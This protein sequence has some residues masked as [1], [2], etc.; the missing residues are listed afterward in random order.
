MTNFFLSRFNYA[1]KLVFAWCENLFNKWRLE[2]KDFTIICATCAGGV[3]THKLGKKFLSP[4]VNLFFPE[5]DVPRL[6]RNLRWY[7]EQ[8]LILLQDESCPFPRGLCGDIP[9][10]FNHAKTFEEGKRIW[11]RRKKR[12]NYDNIWVI[13]SDNEMSYGDIVKFSEMPCKGKIMFTAKEYPE[14]DFCLPFL[15]Y[16]KEGKLSVGEY[17]SHHSKVLDRFIYERYFDYTSWLNGHCPKHSLLYR[18]FYWF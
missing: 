15:E 17:M 18:I 4:T 14:F 8:E 16:K 11:D 3:I 12:I 2:N 9:I 6:V 13:G 5:K 1:M 7:M 10:T